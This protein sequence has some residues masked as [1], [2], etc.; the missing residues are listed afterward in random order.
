MALSRLFRGLL[1]SFSQAPIL[2][3]SEGISRAGGH[4]FGLRGR[5]N[6]A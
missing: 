6:T 4:L 2:A 3:T 1:L 5:K